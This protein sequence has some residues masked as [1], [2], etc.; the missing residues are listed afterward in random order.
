[1]TG[2]ATSLALILIGMLCASA[3]FGVLLTTMLV[4]GNLLHLEGQGSA[5][6]LIYTDKTYLL[7]SIMTSI[8]AVV[9]LRHNVGVAI[10]FVGVAV[11]FQIAEH[12]LLPQMRK[13]AQAGQSLPLISTRARFELFQAICLL[14][15]FANLAMPP[16]I[17]L[18]RVHGL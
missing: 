5:P 11:A 9:S 13:A 2:N 10:S 6:D 14:L 1:M 17:T 18:V 7:A 16:L 4:R 8:G 3:A 12:W 15:V